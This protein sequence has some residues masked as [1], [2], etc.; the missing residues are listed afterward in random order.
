MPF[1]DRHNLIENAR[2]AGELPREQPANFIGRQVVQTSDGVT[3]RAC[4]PADDTISYCAVLTIFAAVV[5]GS[6]VLAVQMMTDQKEDLHQADY[7]VT[8]PVEHD[9][10]VGRICPLVYD[11]AASCFD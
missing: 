11:E 10:A 1:L 6:I 4:K 3:L 2:R 8:G 5:L 9:R 7:R